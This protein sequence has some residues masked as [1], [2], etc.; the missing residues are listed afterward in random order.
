MKLLLLQTD[1]RWLAP[2]ENR[3]RAEEAIGNALPHGS[4][5][6]DLI[7]LP[8][9]FTTG[10]VVEPAGTAEP[11]AGAETLEWMRSMAARTDAAV[12]GSVAV[13][14]RGRYFNRLFF[15]KPD[16]SFS[17]YDKRHLFS[18]AGEDARYTAGTERAVVE[19]RG[20]RILLQVCYDL[21]F[22]VFARN[23]GDYDMA[24]YVASW[25][26]V[27][28]HPWNTLLVARA[29]ENVCWAVG[30]NRTGEDPFASYSGGTA[31]ID[32]KGETAAAATPNSEE[33]VVCEIDMEALRAF[34]A[35]FPALGDADTFT[36]TI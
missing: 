35:K 15:V 16:G 20:W 27:R 33:T 5:A 36:L 17:K 9:M 10:F 8:E 1:T 21:R 7:V 25:P 23:R 30:V 6:V 3:R 34:R 14:E 19:W 28:I 31:L 22:G 13:E 24:L 26:T 11:E 12:A 18:F 4:G 2:D 29:I 32:F